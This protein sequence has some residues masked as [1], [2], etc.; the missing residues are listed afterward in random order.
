[1]S[2]DEAVGYAEVGDFHVELARLRE[3][4]LEGRPLLI[5]GDPR[6][7]GK[8]VA[9]SAELRAR[10]L[11]PGLA[12][13]EALDRAP[14]ALWRRTDMRAARELSGALRGAVRR[15]VE[16]VEVEGLAGFYLRAPRAR[17]AALALAE[18]L[19]AAVEAE[20]G[21]PL[22]V[23]VAPVRFAA[24]MVAGQAGRG[25]V[26]IVLEAGFEDWLLA[27]RLEELPGVG[28]KTAARL[29]ELGAVDVPTLRS[30]GR[31]RLE[32]LLGPHGRALWLLACGEDPRPL[33]TRRQPTTLSREET[34]AGGEGDP[35][36]LA[37][38]LGRL[39]ER[40]DRSLARDG[41]RARRLA[42]RLTLDDSR[43]LTRSRTLEAPVAS[44]GRL[45]EAAR[46]L[47]A[48]LA[49]E[50]HGVRRV[51]LVLKGLEATGGED[52]Q[53]DLF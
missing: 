49:F 41:L 17:E 52:R 48:A 1:M 26:R 45:L 51:G 47:Y 24:R 20:T 22:Q 39:C 11:V 21:L 50:G 46:S 8:V 14:D 43:T 25:G 16:A 44:A 53:L 27:Q 13:Q 38:A 19:R 18:R 40:L 9:A 30:I 7:K 10:G 33:R 29:A 37:A 32:V 36:A 5:G 15:E 31:D 6:K 42:L 34:L 4:A 12:L 28:P 23:G 35:A 3:P 2:R